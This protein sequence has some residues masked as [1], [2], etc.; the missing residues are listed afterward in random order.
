MND[1][2]TSRLRLWREWLQ[3]QLVQEPVFVSLA[4]RWFGWIVALVIVVLG[5][6]PAENLRHAPLMLAL[7][8]GA[9]VC[10][11]LYPGHLRS[12]RP[13]ALDQISPFL[14]PVL[15]T[16]LALGSVYFTGGWE[17]PFYH[18]AVT[19]VLALLVFVTVTVLGFVKNGAKFLELFWVKS[20]PRVRPR[21]P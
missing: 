15:D 2:K 11:S 5:V 17:S 9:L 16:S 14:W 10:M 3:T 7:T 18:F 19:V 21:G 4:L 12:H 8:G 13:S 1:E 6:A 20:A